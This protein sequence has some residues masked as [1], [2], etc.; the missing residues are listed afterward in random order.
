[1]RILKRPGIRV[2]LVYFNMVISV[3]SGSYMGL[4]VGYIE[5]RNLG[6]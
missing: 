6:H 4:T 1:M 3:V 2:S 5:A